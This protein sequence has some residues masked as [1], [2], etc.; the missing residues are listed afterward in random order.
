MTTTTTDETTVEP[1]SVVGA[2]I[3]VHWIPTPS[4]RRLLDHDVETSTS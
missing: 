4:R 2:K 3:G 1:G